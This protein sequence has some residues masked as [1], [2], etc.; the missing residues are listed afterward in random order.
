QRLRPILP[1]K[2]LL[3]D[4]AGTST[5]LRRFQSLKP[6]TV[7]LLHQPSFNEP[8]SFFLDL[9][10]QLMKIIQYRNSNAIMLIQY[11]FS[12]TGFGDV[13]RYTIT[14]TVTITESMQTITF[15]SLLLS[16]TTP[17]LHVVTSRMT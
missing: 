14:L 3:L 1:D 12:K 4:F 7:I 13:L 2:T 17:S 9:E 15:R 8:A 11:G 10:Y 5:I 16:V 6:R